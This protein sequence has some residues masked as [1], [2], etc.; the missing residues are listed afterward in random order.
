MLEPDYSYESIKVLND[1]SHAWPKGKCS[2]YK[3]NV[4]NG[5]GVLSQTETEETTCVK[6]AKNKKI[7]LTSPETKY[8]SDVLELFSI[9][10]GTYSTTH[11]KELITYYSIDNKNKE[12]INLLLNHDKQFFGGT[13]KA[14]VFQNNEVVS[15][16][17]ENTNRDREF[18]LIAKIKK[19]NVK[20]SIEERIM[21]EVKHEINEDNIVNI[22]EIIMDSEIDF[23]NK[24]IWNLYEEHDGLCE[25]IDDYIYKLRTLNLRLDEY[26]SIK[27]DTASEQAVQ[28]IEKAGLIT[29]KIEE[30]RKKA[31][32]IKVAMKNIAKSI[33]FVWEKQ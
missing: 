3:E 2:I 21:V 15:C 16:E 17:T 29:Q 28:L 20:A 24:E 5:D 23:D 9:K 11:K 8:P 14:E 1:S 7:S 13:I 10:N 25:E 30:R 19:G 6:Y 32:D 12:E 31:L 18:R 27:G 4:F 26:K 33:D 22:F